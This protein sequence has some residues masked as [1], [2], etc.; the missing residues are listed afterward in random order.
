M[1][2]GEGSQIEVSDST[3][4]IMDFLDRK[5]PEL[6]RFRTKKSILD[7]RFSVAER[8][9]HEEELAGA[10]AKRDSNWD[11]ESSAE[12]ADA[13]AMF[14]FIAEDMLTDSDR[15]YAYVSQTHPYDDELNATDAVVAFCSASDPECRT[16]RV[17]VD[18][19]SAQNTDV[20][21]VKE[22]RNNER[23]KRGKFTSLKYGPIPDLANLPLVT[24]AFTRKHLAEYAVTENVLSGEDERERRER[25][26]Q[27]PIRANMLL[28]MERQL[29]EQ[30]E[31]LARA[32]DAGRINDEDAGK[33]L[34]NIEGT[35]DAI[36][37]NAPSAEN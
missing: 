2:H 14:P 37:K 33:V 32:L 3:E 31:L 17:A 22:Q 36:A 19:T 11:I 24:I 26:H 12:G 18:V 34:E 4:A 10:R 1:R 27:L 8:A 5:Q 30:R 25:L 16:Y 13:E 15:V 29:I 7:Q 9:E 28:Q 23:A 6:K 21:H 20:L 35:L